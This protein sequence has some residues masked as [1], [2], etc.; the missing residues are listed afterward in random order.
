M[1][2]L[3]LKISLH[4]PHMYLLYSSSTPSYALSISN[5][6]EGWSI[7]HT[8]AQTSTEAQ[9]RSYVLC[10]RGLYQ[11]LDKRYLFWGSP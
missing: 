1:G 6:V 3:I 8:H 2:A 9:K 5:S 10:R 11:S 4:N 7:Q